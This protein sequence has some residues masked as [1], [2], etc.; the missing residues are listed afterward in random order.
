MM[1]LTPR[2]CNWS[3]MAFGA[4]SSVISVWMRDNWQTAMEPRASNFEESA[5]TTSCSGPCQQLG[6]GPGNQRIA[7]DHTHLRYCI[8]AHEHFGGS[9][10]LNGVF[11]KGREDDAL[12]A[13]DLAARYD[14]AVVA[15][16][17]QFLGDG[18][19]S[20]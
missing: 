2:D 5:S 13:V 4:A 10:V 11:V 3:S 1:M 19:K 16:G 9:E 18:K 8:A 6:L 17:D 12:F 7:F 20:W 14:D 15:G